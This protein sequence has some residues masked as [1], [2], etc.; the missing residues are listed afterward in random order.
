MSQTTLSERFDRPGDT[1][2]PKPLKTMLALCPGADFVS[3]YLAHAGSPDWCILT[4]PEDEIRPDAAVMISSTDIYDVT[5]G[6]GYDENTP[7]KADCP[8]ARDEAMFAEYCRRYDLPCV[9][10]RAANIVGTGMTGLPMRMA[11]GIARGTL[12]HIQGNAETA[13]SVVHALDVA[14]LSFALQSAPGIYNVT[15][16]SATTVDALMDAFAHR[17]SD[18]NVGRIRRRWA[19]W[20]YGRRYYERLTHTLT[21]DDAHLHQTLAQLGADTPMIHVVERLNTHVYSQDDI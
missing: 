5:E 2:I 20:L 4:R 3:K 19:R 7:I 17:L 13:I 21:F 18:K 11:R 16:G 9:I 15:D 12:M 10:L 1:P 14:R 8:T 6:N